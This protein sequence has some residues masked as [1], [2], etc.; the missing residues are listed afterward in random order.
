[1][2]SSNLTPPFLLGA[3]V[4]TPNNASASDQA[5]FINDFNAF[6]NQLGAA[7]AL[8]DTYVNQN[9]PI[10]NWSSQNGWQA[11]SW[12]STPLLRD[13]LP[14]IGLPIRST[15]DNADQDYKDFASGEYD[16][17]ISTMVSTWVSAGYQTQ[18]WRLGWK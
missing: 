5:A 11:A 10:S 3:F 4:G 18:Y 8:L 1:M 2:A 17:L 6:A 9:E 15:L 12:S 16:G 14:V 7:P 13:T